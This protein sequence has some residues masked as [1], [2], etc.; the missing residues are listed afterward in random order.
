MKNKEQESKDLQ[1]QETKEVSTAVNM[2]IFAGTG[3]E[4]TTSETFMIP[5]IYIVQ[6]LSGVKK[7]SDPSYRK[8]AVDGQFYSPALDRLF[9]TLH[10]RVLSIE[11]QVIVWRPRKLG[12]GLVKI[13]PKTEEGTIKL[14]KVDGLKKWTPEGNEVVDT[15]VFTLQDYNNPEDIFFFPLSKT[16]LKYARR[17]VSRINKIKI[18]PETLAIDPENGKLG[19][20]S[21]VVKW[22][23]TTKVESNDE[24]EWYS[25]GNTP[26]AIGTVSKDELPMIQKALEMIKT[27]KMDTSHMEEM[28]SG[29]SEGMEDYSASVEGF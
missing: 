13:V 6:A 20:S 22:D 11:H 5:M 16:A 18:N 1:E 9:D 8:D 4:G 19:A 12:G 14:G 23:I 21:W 27:A 10:V 29:A 24:G 25:I 15:I 3:F 26:D 2:D 7:V 28:Q 17:W